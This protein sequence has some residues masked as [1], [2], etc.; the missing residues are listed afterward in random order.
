METV[1]VLY[2]TTS[3][4]IIFLQSHGPDLFSQIKLF[5]LFLF[6]LD[7]NIKRK[8]W[9][10]R[11]M[12]MFF[13]LAIK[14]LCKCVCE[15]QRECKTVHGR[16]RPVTGF[17]P[18]SE[19]L[20]HQRNRKVSAAVIYARVCRDVTFILCTW[21]LLELTFFTQHWLQISE[22]KLRRRSDINIYKEFLWRACALWIICSAG[23]THCIVLTCI[24]D[25]THFYWRY[26][27]AVLI[28][29]P[30]C[31]GSCAHCGAWMVLYV[32]LVESE[33]KRLERLCEWGPPRREP[34]THTS[35]SPPAA[36]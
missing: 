14:R 8:I 31:L 21:E 19:G 24:K 10:F 15:T 32:C 33:S 22:F 23:R 29:S 5:S 17:S 11:K 2:Y 13:I 1:T 27:H 28:C 25:W 36:S 16:G 30:F 4:L 34:S 26:C 3:S 18:N 12:K 9:D 35:L 7:I 6:L 20:Q